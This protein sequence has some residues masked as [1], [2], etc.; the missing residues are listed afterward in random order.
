MIRLLAR[1]HCLFYGQSRTVTISYVLI[2]YAPRPPDYTV[3][4]RC[5]RCLAR[6]PATVSGGTVTIPGMVVRK[7]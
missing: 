2:S 4:V 5:A 3:V 1:L 7:G 6:L